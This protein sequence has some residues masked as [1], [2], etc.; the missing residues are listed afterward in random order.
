MEGFLAIFVTIAVGLVLSGIAYYIWKPRE[1][2]VDHYNPLSPTLQW[3]NT[4]GSILIAANGGLFHQMAGTFYP[5]DELHPDRV[6]RVQRM[7]RNSWGIE[8]HDKAMDEMQALLDTGMRAE[9]AEDMQTLESQ[10][11]GF[12]EEEL[13]REAQKQ[14]PNAD[15]DSYLPKMLMA[16]RQHGENALLGW[17]LG[18]AAFVIQACY[19]A[20]YVSMEEVLEIGVEAGKKAQAV[21]HSWE[22]MMESYLLGTQYWQQEE[23]ND[24]KSI[25]ANR[26]KLY[27]KLWRGDN[28][29]RVCPYLSIPFDL[30]LS[31]EIITDK[32]GILP[33]YQKKK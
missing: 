7:L 1:K 25:T 19:F 28:F 21:F 18:R 27:K 12:S 32:Y 14:A 22:E 17:D 24:P 6:Q 33:E 31:K 11:A 15:E 10:Y 29:F 4:A 13:I 26:W 30:E 3:M 2:R 23:R 20:G 5:G 9:Y 8:T 16:Y